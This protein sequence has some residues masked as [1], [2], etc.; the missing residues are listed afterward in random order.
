M[1]V[2]TTTGTRLFSWRQN[3]EGTWP[4]VGQLLAQNL[5]HPGGTQARLAIHSTKVRVRVAYPTA[6]PFRFSGFR[7]LVCRSG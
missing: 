3:Y 7:E 1:A 6:T 5:N 4:D 2:F